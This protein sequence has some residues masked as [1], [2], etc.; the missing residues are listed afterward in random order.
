M[1]EKSGCGCVESCKKLVARFDGLP[2]AEKTIKEFDYNLSALEKRV[3]EL[4]KT[5]GISEVSD[6]VYEE[7]FRSRS[8]RPQKSYCLCRSKNIFRLLILK[9]Y[10]KLGGKY[11]T[12]IRS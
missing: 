5:D 9:A 10:S 7:G 8:C 1:T 2:D 12:D 11:R 4:Q 3:E 6:A